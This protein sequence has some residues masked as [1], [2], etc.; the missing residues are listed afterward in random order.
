[1]FRSVQIYFA[2]GLAAFTVILC[3]SVKSCYLDPYVFCPQGVC[4]NF[5]TFSFHEPL[6]FRDTTVICWNPKRLFHFCIAASTPDDTQTII[7][8]NFPL[9][10]QRLL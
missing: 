6:L 1:M 7:R 10:K 9:I 8:Q 2:I 4:Q 5:Y 3:P